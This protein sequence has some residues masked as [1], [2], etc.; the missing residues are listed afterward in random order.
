VVAE[1]DGKRV[2]PTGWKGRSGKWSFAEAVSQSD[3]G[4]D[5]QAYASGISLNGAKQVSVT[6]KARKI[7]GEEGFI[8]MLGSDDGFKAQWNLGGW[9]NEKHAWQIG[10]GQPLNNG[11][12]GKIETGRWYDIRLE[13]TGSKLRGYL[14]GKLIQEADVPNTPDFAQVAG[15]DEARKELVVKLVNGAATARSIQIETR[16]REVASSARVTVLTGPSLSVENDLANPK[17][18]APKT[19]TQDLGPDL[20]YQMPPRSVSILRLRLE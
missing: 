7:A 4:Q 20:T 14:D 6:L 10:G 8:V 18:V 19:K 16:G 2:T 11:V 3:L 17:R 9:G 5:R 15:V 13:K 1:I 12:P